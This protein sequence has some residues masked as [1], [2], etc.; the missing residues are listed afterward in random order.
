MKNIDKLIYTYKHRKIV[1]FLGKKYSNNK[2]LLKQL[3]YHDLDKMFLLL[4]YD[5]D[6]VKKIHRETSHHHDNNLD[7]TKLDYMEMVLD[8]ESARYTKPDKPLNAYDT[9][10]K[11]YPH[12]EENIIPILKEF[13]IDYSSTN[14]EDDVVDYVNTLESIDEN[15]IKKELV[16]CINKIN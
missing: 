5:K 8:W 10:Y 9:L 12:L 13:G 3:E 11:Y 7:K 14:M 16:Y 15:D 2:E 4:F 1:Y 6:I